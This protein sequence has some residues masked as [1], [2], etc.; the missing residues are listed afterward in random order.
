[1]HLCLR[2]TDRSRNSEIDDSWVG[3][4]GV[5]GRNFIQNGLTIGDSDAPSGY[6]NALFWKAINGDNDNPPNFL[7]GAGAASVHQGDSINIGATYYSNVPMAHFGW[8]DLTSGIVIGVDVTSIG[9]YSI[10]GYYDGSSAEYINENVIGTQPRSFADVT[11][12]NTLTP[13]KSRSQ[14]RPRRS[15][16]L[17]G[18]FRTREQR[19]DWLG[20]R[21]TFVSD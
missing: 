12:N 20:S 19:D 1:M 8:H 15:P 6:P 14:S 18:I 9:G 2:P 17:R 5:Y 13:T 3:V 7:T 10:S 21:L 16:A 4:G 11:W